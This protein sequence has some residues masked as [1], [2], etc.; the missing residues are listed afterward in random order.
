V[1]ALALTRLGRR[2]G[3][4]MIDRVVGDKALPAEVAAQ[5]IAKTDGVPLFV[6]ELTKTVL[7]SG[8]LMDAGD[9]YELAGPLPPLA[10]P[11]TLHDSLLARL[12]RL[13]P[14]KE[15][16]Q[17]GAVIGREFSH[18]LLAAVAER[19]AADLQAAL[20]QLVAAELIFRRGAPPDVTYSFKHALVQD[21]A[22][23]TLL[24]SR[25]Q[26]LHARI[27]KVL[28]ERFS[29][30]AKNQPEQLA[31]H[32]TEAHQIERAFEYW[33][34]A[35]ERAVARSA[36][37]EAIR[38]LTRGLEALEAL[39]EGPE[40]DRRELALQ[41]GIGT[42]LI[43]VQGYAAPQTGAAYSRARA[44]CE[45][46][47]QA[48]P[49]VATLSGEFVYYFVRGE[50]SAM[51]RLADEARHVSERLPDPVVRLASH[52]LAGITA[53]HGGAFAQAR[54]E[55]EAILGL[56]DASQH[57]SQPVHYVH[58]PKVSALTY[59]APVL[60]MTGFP[61]QA[62]RASVAAFRCAGEL[63]QANL[64]AHV[65]NFAGAGLE[66]LLGNIPAVRAHA[67]AILELAD[68]HDLG[69]W[70]LNGLI[71]RGWAMVQEGAEEAGIA[72]MRHNTAERAA[73][74][75]SWYQA[76]YLCLLA[77]AYAQVGQVE[78]GLHVIAEAKELL[79]RNEEHMWEGELN[80][81]E[82]ELVRRADSCSPDVQACFGRAIATTRQ[83]GAKS[84]EL[85]AATSLA[86]LW[87][88]Q[89]RHAEARD[90]LAPVYGWFTEGFET[91][92]LQ[93]AKALLEELA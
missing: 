85:R 48:E 49:L 13:A 25:R 60:W 21:V 20:D 38:H 67:D 90:L 15:I 8:L 34:K 57:R 61:E 12:D 53:M 86:R 91:R 70:R 42:P 72:L 9:H 46:L 77:A 58:D 44:L 63:D 37:V 78:P 87:R 50:Y 39:P 18:A 81:I 52:R 41:I 65:H 11:A 31:H 24:K 54:S 82:G 62:Q 22:Y 66:E 2:D 55:F 36:N 4:A 7:E 83:Q 43:A 27:A 47:G 75:V 59:L 16:A 19:S 56:Y 76:R 51:R 88:D 5:I 92:D 80:R 45:R 40:R 93:D 23:G 33:R 84:L 29:E 30:T 73:L 89:G 10:L 3:S 35:G 26:H 14:V 69:Y 71:L 28:E 64:A 6:E 74:G 68:R 32:F 1:S 79:A 17:I